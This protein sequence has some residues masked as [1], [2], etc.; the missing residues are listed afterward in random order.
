MEQN[1]V[2]KCSYQRYLSHVNLHLLPTTNFF[3]YLQ[4]ILNRILYTRSFGLILKNSEKAPGG[5][6][7]FLLGSAEIGKKKPHPLG[8]FPRIY[9]ISLTCVRL[10]NKFSVSLFAPFHITRNLYKNTSNKK[11][12]HYIAESHTFLFGG[13]D[14]L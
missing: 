2:I 13:R 6:A 3:N 8:L 12:G 1:V 5:G 14:S 4:N 11:L 10:E 7:F 9:C